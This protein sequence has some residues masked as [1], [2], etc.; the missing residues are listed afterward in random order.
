MRAQQA[1]PPERKVVK[2][3][4]PEYPMVLRSK[5]IG[6]TVKLEVTVTAGGT[7]K[8]VQV[9]G[10]NAILAESAQHAVRQWVFA[11][12]ERETKNTVVIEFNP[13]TH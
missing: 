11:A 4:Q 7:V 5:G 8:A 6:G 1:A 10:G 9:L 13:E 2:R 3:V 12:G